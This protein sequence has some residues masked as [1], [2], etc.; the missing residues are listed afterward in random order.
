ME[1][2]NLDW[3]HVI[4]TPLSWN[5]AKHALDPRTPHHKGK[6]FTL[7]FE[8]SELEEPHTK[9]WNV[10]YVFNI[11]VVHVIFKVGELIFIQCGTH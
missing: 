5:I 6:S 8:A 4:S 7:K 9:Y 1:S 2:R 11:D 3:Y 10:I